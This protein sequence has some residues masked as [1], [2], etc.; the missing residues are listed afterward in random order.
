M[1]HTLV[2]CSFE[3]IRERIKNEQFIESVHFLVERAD[4]GISAEMIIDA[5]GYDSPKICENY[6]NDAPWPACLILGNLPDGT[7]MHVVLA[8]NQTTIKIVTAY[9]NPDRSK[10]LDDLCTRRRQ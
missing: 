1:T 8:Y 10:W 9:L 3:S 4:R 6:P 7:P 2:G 5:V